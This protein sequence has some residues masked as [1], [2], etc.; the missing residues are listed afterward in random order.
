MTTPPRDWFWI[1]LLAPA[2]WAV[3]N[4]ID[5]YLLDRDFRSKGIGP[6]LV[7][8][9]VIGL[10]AATAIL[11]FRPGVLAIAPEHAA[12]VVLNGALYV[13]SLVPYYLALR[14]DE[15]SIVVP[16]FQTTAVFSYGF[17]LLILGERLTSAQL[18][19]AALILGGSVLLTLEL[20]KE[21]TRFKL[22]VF[23]LMMVASVINAL[24]WLLF[25]YVAVREDFWR[26]SFWEYVGFLSVAVCALLF[27]KRVRRTFFD[28]LR[29]NRPRTLGLVTL[30][31]V[32]SL[33]AKTATNA[34]SLTAPLALISTVHGFQPFFVLLYGV[35]LTVLAPGHV[36]EDLTHVALFQKATAITL[37]VCGTWMLS[38]G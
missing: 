21:Q 26:T 23:L 17:G 10:V 25:K 33:G 3:G 15:A 8:S 9:S 24:N 6:L 13:L 29:E 27:V 28:V 1:A 5:K 34:A 37:T 22:D 19:A 2:L 20:H 4:H 38:A 14:R 36:R 12:L 32:V 16:L 7:F 30:N 18:A 35:L 31:E 11:F